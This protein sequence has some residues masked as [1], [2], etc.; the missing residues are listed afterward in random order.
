MVRCVPTTN[1]Y[2]IASALAVVV[3]ATAPATAKIVEV[4]GDIHLAGGEGEVV[5]GGVDDL[6]RD[7]V[8]EHGQ[9]PRRQHRRPAVGP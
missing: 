7:R 6:E 9:H 2:D 3:V 1:L 4:Y 8:E 5:H